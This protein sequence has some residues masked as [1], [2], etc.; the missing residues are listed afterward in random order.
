[1]AVD[2]RNADVRRRLADAAEAS[3]SGDARALDLSYRDIA[4][5]IAVQDRGTAFMDRLVTAAVKSEDPLFRTNAINALGG[6][7]TPETVQRALAIAQDERLLQSTERLR[8]TFT[9]SGQA[10][11]RDALFAMLSSNWDAATAR[12][13]AFVRPQLPMLFGSYCEPAR[14]QAVEALFAPRLAS[15]G[16]GELELRQETSAIRNCAAL[17]E[18]KGAEIEAALAR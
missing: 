16:G 2:A 14:A 18:A 6:A 9:L 10:A 12:I 15:S 7:D 1:M 17:K 5:R 13:P 11:G 3:L 8:L 4:L